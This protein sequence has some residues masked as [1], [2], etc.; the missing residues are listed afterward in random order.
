MLR[1]MVV[2]PLYGGS[3]PVG[4]Y[5][6]TAL[7]E[8]GHMVEVFEAPDFFG[9]YKAMESLKVTPE[10][11]EYLQN[12]YLQVVAQAVGAKVET[13]APDLV[14]A[15]AQAPMS[16]QLLKRLR[17][18]G[19]PT[20]MWF[21]EDYRLFTYWQ[22]YAPYYDLFCV[23]QKEPFFSQLE[24]IGQHNHLYLPLAAEPGT[25]RPLEL[26]P[27]DQKTYG[28]SVSFMG[29]GYPNRRLAFH[30]LVQPGFKIWGT[31]WD[32]DPVLAPYVQ[33]DGKRVTPEEC[34]KIFNATEINLNLHSSVQA[35]KLVS[36]GDFVNPRTFELAACGAFQ[37]VDE[38]KLL[39]EHFAQDEL[40]TFTDIEELRE[41]IEYFRSNPDEVAEYSQKA[42]KR[43]LK[44]HTYAHR[45]Q[46]LIDFATERLENWPSHNSLNSF[47]ELGLSEDVKVKLEE[48]RLELEL[49]AGVSFEDM[50]WALR[51]KNTPLTGLESSLLFL[52]EWKKQY[53]R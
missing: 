9:A 8:L 32:G 41:K 46:A 44:E 1:V 51:Q 48:L 43:V 22:A 5:C 38:R 17:R 47:E 31:D 25:H 23:I 18:D 42:R 11:L 52:D 49:P 35:D 20:A 45:M 12:S 33:M 50:I 37:L 15:M 53:L 40:A 34:A 2:L 36:F 13:F 6:A 26:S 28:S 19:V 3:L 10:R 7:K 21:V 24:A 16:R 29:A 39:P 14:L 27:A 30:K 4:R